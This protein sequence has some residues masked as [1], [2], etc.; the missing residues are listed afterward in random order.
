MQMHV[1]THMCKTAVD[2]KICDSKYAIWLGPMCR[3]TCVLRLCGSWSRPA[4]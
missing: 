4:A 3:F 1:R 2:C